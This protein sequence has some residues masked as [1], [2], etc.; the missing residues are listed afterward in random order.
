MVF[1]NFDAAVSGFSRT[2][3][4]AFDCSRVDAIEETVKK[5][6]MVLDNFDMTLEKRF[7]AQGEMLDE[8]FAE[9]NQNVAVVRSDI[10]ALQRDMTIVREGI[11]IILGKLG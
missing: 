11:K 7:R 8:R 6:D 4:S 3:G 10:S 1:P 2:A 9:V 5:F